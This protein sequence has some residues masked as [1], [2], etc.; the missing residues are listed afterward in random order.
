MDKF[1]FTLQTVIKITTADR[2]TANHH[3][4]S[5]A[6]GQR[7]VEAVKYMQMNITGQYPTDRHQL[8]KI[9]KLIALK[10]MG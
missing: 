4:A 3:F 5:N 10:I 2:Q 6:L 1:F 7:I 9:G 8:L